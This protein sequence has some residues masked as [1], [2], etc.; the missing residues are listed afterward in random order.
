[1]F[2]LLQVFKQLRSHDMG[3]GVGGGVNDAEVIDVSTYTS[4]LWFQP[5]LESQ[6]FISNYAQICLDMHFLMGKSLI[7]FLMRI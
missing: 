1:M 4:F 5:A 6:Q 3:C 2:L 7:T